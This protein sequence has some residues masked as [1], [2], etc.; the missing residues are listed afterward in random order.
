MKKSGGLRNQPDLHHDPKYQDLTNITGRSVGWRNAKSGGE[1][2]NSNAI[3]D[4]SPGRTSRE[5]PE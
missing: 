3:H 1:S 4:Q 5:Y 2:R